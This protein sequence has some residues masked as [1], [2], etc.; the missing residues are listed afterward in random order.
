MAMRWGL[1]DARSYD[2]PVE[3]RYDTLWRR[4][5]HEGG[6]TDTPTTSAKLTEQALPA[7]RLLSVTDVAQDPDDPRVT[8]LRSPLPTTSRTCACTAARARCRGPASWLSA[9]GS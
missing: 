8:S 3:R 9:S 1:Y 4:A 7:L 2:L 6:P 5:V